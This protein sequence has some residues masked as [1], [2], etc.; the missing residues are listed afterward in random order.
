[1]GSNVVAVTFD[2]PGER[3]SCSLP[4]QKR[5]S[6]WAWDYRIDARPMSWVGRVPACLTPQFGEPPRL[7]L[8]HRDEQPG[9]APL[10]QGRSQ[11]LLVQLGKPGA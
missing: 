3:K 8:A 1:M 2:L 9:A 10:G 6:L 5:A 11:A 7:P 4:G